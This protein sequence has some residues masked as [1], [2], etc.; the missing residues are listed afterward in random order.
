MSRAKTLVH[1]D[2]R[3]LFACLVLAGCADSHGQ[4]DGPVGAIAEPTTEPAAEAASESTVE[5]AAEPTDAAPASPKP[6]FAPAVAGDDPCSAPGAFEPLQ[7]FPGETC[8]D[9]VPHAPE[10][11][12]VPFEQGQGEAYHVWNHAIPWA[13]DAVATR[14]GAV[15]DDADVNYQWYVFGSPKGNEA[16]AVSMYV[17]NTTPGPDATLFAHWARSRCNVELPKSVGLQLPHEGTV[18]VVRHMVNYTGES[19]LDAS[20]LRICTVPRTSRS[21]VASMTVLGTESLNPIEGFPPGLH[22]FSGTCTNRALDAVEISLVIPHMHEYGIRTQLELLPRQEGPPQ[23][24]LSS[25]FDP[26]ARSYHVFD[27]PVVLGVGDSLVASCSYDNDSE[28]NLYF[29]ESVVMEQC[30][31]YALTSPARALEDGSL[32]LLGMNNACW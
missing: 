27:A 1:R 23:Q 17:T 26:A 3:L 15:L 24:L 25:A 20:A 7:P 28:Y 8:Y 4:S 16:E 21:Q 6:G 31:V 11:V 13:E 22:T 14:F 32:S 18:V 19:R 5:V 12:D 29:G 30:Y 10:G 9:F 2:P